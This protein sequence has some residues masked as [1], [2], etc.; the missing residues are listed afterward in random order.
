MSKIN[1]LKDIISEIASEHK[2]LF[3]LGLITLLLVFVAIM[4]TTK[5]SM[6]WSDKQTTEQQIRNIRH[7]LIEYDEKAAKLEHSSFRPVPADQIDSV[8]AS[9]LSNVQN[10]NLNLKSLKEITQQNQ[11]K[12]GR[13]FQIDFEGDFDHTVLFLNNFGVNHA[14][15]A[16][17]SIHL[18]PQH[19]SLNT[20][21]DYKIYTTTSSGGEKQ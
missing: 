6:A 13:V 12:N 5:L 18:I 11:E 19:N 17:K 10:H 3:M 14:L 4:L 1:D 2:K 9:L 7:F 15:I 21:L 20:K 8:Q 16:I